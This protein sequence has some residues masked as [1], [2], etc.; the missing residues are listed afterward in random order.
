MAHSSIPCRCSHYDDSVRCSAMATRQV[1]FKGLVSAVAGLLCEAHAEIIERE[2]QQQLPQ[3]GLECP[4]I[5]ATMIGWVDRS[6]PEFLRMWA[7][8]EKLTPFAADRPDPQT[9]EVWQYMGSCLLG[10]AWWH[11]FRHRSLS[12]ERRRIVLRATEGWEPVRSL[13]ATHA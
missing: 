3:L 2:Y 9:G 6:N 10:D 7:S 12:G 5:A 4:P 11:E 13:E 1:A 8:F